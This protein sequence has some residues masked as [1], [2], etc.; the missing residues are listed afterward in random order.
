MARLVRGEGSHHRACTAGAFVDIV[1]GPGQ[2]VG[3]VALGDGYVGGGLGQGNGVLF[4]LQRLDL[5]EDIETAR[6]LRGNGGDLVAGAGFCA[7]VPHDVVIAGLAPEETNVVVRSIGTRG[8][9]PPH[10]DDVAFLG[11][12][13]GKQLLLGAESVGTDVAVFNEVFVVG[14]PCQPIVRQAGAVLVH[15]RPVHDLHGG[16][17]VQAGFAE[18]VADKARAVHSHGAAVVGGVTF[19]RLGVAA[20][21]GGA[22]VVVVVLV[23]LQLLDNAFPGNAHGSHVVGAALHF[24]FHRVEGVLR[25]KHGNVPGAVRDDNRVFCLR[26]FFFLCL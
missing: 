9:A 3:A 6:G 22:Q 26:R 15:G 19:G 20:S 13:T 23:G 4:G 11:Q 10:E 12:A 1:G 25:V 2:R 14:G 24:G 16:F 17:R 21:V 5:D 7:A 18:N 8:V